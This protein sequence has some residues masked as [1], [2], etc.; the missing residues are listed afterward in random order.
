MNIERLIL[1]LKD[2]EGFSPVAFW[3]REQWTYGYGCKAPG[4]GSTITK[5]KA[6]VLLN[7]EVINSM[8]DFMDIYS[9]C[10]ENINDVRA[11][12]LVN[13][14]FNLGKTKLLKFR[15]MNAA[16]RRDDWMEAAS[17]AAS[18]RWYAQVGKR[19]WR[20]CKELATGEKGEA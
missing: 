5:A 17:Q 18:S 8:K 9:D 13:M 2:D 10:Q 20:I 15:K 3:D 19:A 6:D 1:Q 7:D 4:E 16:I 12:A 14:A 11:E